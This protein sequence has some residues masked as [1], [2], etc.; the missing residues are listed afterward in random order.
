MGLV[1]ILILGQFI[2]CL[3]SDGI[4]VGIFLWGL[5]H[6]FYLRDVDFI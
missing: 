2:L 6:L 5:F 1:L 4:L 3:C